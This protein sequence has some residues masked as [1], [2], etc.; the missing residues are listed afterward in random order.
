MSRPKKKIVLFLVEGKTDINVLSNPFLSLFEKHSFS[1]NSYIVEFCTY[2]QNDQNGGDITSSIG[3]TPEN[4]EGIISKNFIAPFM[5]KNPQFYI[6]DVCEVIQIV[7][8]DGA[9]A[10]DECIIQKEDLPEKT[11]EYTL[12][13][14]ICRNA[15]NIIDRNE[16]KRANLNK[17]ISMD[18]ISISKNGGKNSKSINYSVYYFS[19]NMDH[20]I[21]GKLNPS[22]PEK[23]ELCDEFSSKIDDSVKFCE[24]LNSQNICC[25]GM[26]YKESWDYIMKEGLYS[27]E[28]HTNLNVLIEKI[29][30]MN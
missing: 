20:A 30:N 11:I 17:L 8:L 25:E 5:A 24:Y 15:Q 9:F 27:L 12:N 3:V 26:G 28:R 14:I 16:R 7:D 18:K 22:P 23:V 1:D 21:H 4:I 29:K 6:K 10:P 13:S 2:H 19:R